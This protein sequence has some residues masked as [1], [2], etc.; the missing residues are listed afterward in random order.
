MPLFPKLELR[1]SQSLVM[2]PQLMQAI[3]L[4]QLSSLDLVAYVEEELER[5]PLLERTDA[6]EGAGERA[7]PDDQFAGA[8]DEKNGTASADW[9]DVPTGGD[10]DLASEKLDADFSNVFPDD[11]GASAD[12]VVPSLPIETWTTAP[13]RQAISA[14]DYNLEAFVADSESLA[15]HLIGQSLCRGSKPVDCVTNARNDVQ[16]ASDAKSGPYPT[17]FHAS[18]QT[19]SSVSAT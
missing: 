7:G 8:L 15:D 9:L 16:S 14:D 11:H 19:P 13:T 18:V 12:E 2:T 3:K 17:S 10:Q 1:Q 6:D 4:L 5:N